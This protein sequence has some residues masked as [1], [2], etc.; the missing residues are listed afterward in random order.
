M[1]LFNI[2]FAGAGRVAGALG[3]AFS[4]AGSKIVQVV[5]PSA[6]RGKEMAGRYGASWSD[7]LTF[8]DETEIIIVAVPDHLL[9]E[10]AAGIECSE[11]TITVHT[12][13]SYGLDVF[14]PKLRRTGVFYPLQTFTEGRIISF[15][16]LPVFIEASDSRSLEILKSM[17]ESLGAEAFMAGTERRRMLHL[18]A[19]FICNFTNHM[20]HAG[21]GIVK[22]AG[23]SFE[24]LKPLLD[25]TVRKAMEI[26][27][28]ESQT[29][30]ALRRDLNTIRSHLE[31]LSYSP[32]LQKVYN[33]ISESIISMDKN[34]SG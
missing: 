17:A 29:G 25:E 32:E 14:P 26:G 31:L 16:E 34:I 6:E 2:S 11:E 21:L 15:R 30:P 28:A 4:S 24:V 22:K 20:L 18:S 7:R 13:G 12:A 19:V 9:E 10:V 23:F 1:S 8:S 33:D 5:S 27:P 3:H